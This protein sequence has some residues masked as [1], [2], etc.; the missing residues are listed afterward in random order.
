MFGKKNVVVN[1]FMIVVVIIIINILSSSFALC[2][3]IIVSKAVTIS[4]HTCII[5]YF[6]LLEK[7]GLSV[8]ERSRFVITCQ[9]KYFTG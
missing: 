9:L 7:I 5:P 2:I 3:V 8:F 1:Y 4:V 6:E